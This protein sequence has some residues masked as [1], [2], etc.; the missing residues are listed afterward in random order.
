[1]KG[2]EQP[3]EFHPEGDV[4]THTLIMLDRLENPSLPLA[5]GVLLHDVGKPPTFRVA[6]RIR[7]DEHEQVGARMTSEIL[8]RLRFSNETNERVRAL[9]ANHMK[10]KD[11]Q[12]MRDST[13]KRFLRS[14]HFDEHLDLHRIDCLSS[15]GYLDSYEFVKERLAE[16]PEEELRPPRL[17]TGDDLIAEGYRPGPQFA[18]MLRAVED[19]QL[20]GRIHS[21][22]E[23]LSLIRDSFGSAG[24]K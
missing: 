19:A 4:W 14:E 6:D 12:K 3:P 16:T 15:H 22:E 5:L 7:F 10:F 23:A 21:R 20:E 1:M 9:V 24:E 2:V 18:E 13:L 17:I 8:E 11:V